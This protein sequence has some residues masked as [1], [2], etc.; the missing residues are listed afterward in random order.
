MGGPGI[1]KAKRV[2]QRIAISL[3]W[4]PRLEGMLL[5]ACPAVAACSVATAAPVRAHYGRWDSGGRR[6]VCVVLPVF[7]SPGDAAVR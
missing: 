6:D 7:V 5:A 4:P 2:S 1:L 3:T